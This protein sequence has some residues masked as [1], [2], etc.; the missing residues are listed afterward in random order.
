[1]A[2]DEVT[3]FLALDRLVLSVPNLRRYPSTLLVEFFYPLIQSAQDVK[4][5][6]SQMGGVGADNLLA[7]RVLWTPQADG[8]TLTSDDVVEAYPNLRRL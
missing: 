3:F 4:Q 1:L 6:L 8:D 7:M 5:A 2:I